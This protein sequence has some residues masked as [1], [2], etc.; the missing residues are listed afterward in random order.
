MLDRTGSMQGKK[1]EQARKSLLFCLNNLHTKDR[2]DVITFN[3]LPDVLLPKPGSGQR[4]ERGK[5]RRFVENIE[6]SRRH[7]HRRCAEGG[8]ESGAGRPGTQ[9]MIV[10]LTDGLPTV[11][12]TNI[13]TILQHFKRTE[14]RAAGGEERTGRTSRRR[15][16]RRFTGRGRSARQDAE[17]S[18]RAHLLLRAG[19]RCQRAV[20]G[21]AGAQEKGDS[22]YVKPEEDVE[23]KVSAFFAKVASPILSER[24]AGVRRRG[25]LR[26]LPEAAARPVQRFATG[27]HRAVPGRPGGHR[28]P[29]GHGERQSG[30]LQDGDAIRHGGR[31]Q[32][33]PAAH[34]G[35]AQARLSDRPGAASDNPGRATK[36]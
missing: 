25:R 31:Q 1:I 23:A 13:N 4:R 22:D 18:P 11:G 10:F 12:E 24:E 28:A 32:H 26:R 8:A 21:P 27:H 14:R 19:L 30:D 29:V 17:R 36:K 33:L 9:N 6:A 34:L 2:F 5:A 35:A 7:Q 15:L 3:E 16:D 20:P